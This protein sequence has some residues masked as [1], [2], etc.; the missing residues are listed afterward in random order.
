M[1]IE[2]LYGKDSLPVQ[3][4]PDWDVSIIRKKAMPILADAKGAIAAALA[5]PVNVAPL[6]EEAKGARSAC[7][8][9]CDITRPVP[10]GLFLPILV[11]QLLDAG[12]AA[13]K[14]TIL[15][16][17]GLHRPNE[18]DEMRELV[19]DDWVM[20]TVKVA[21][22][23]ARND[24]DHVDL[25]V[26]PRGTAVKIDRRFVEADI[27]IATGL[28]EPHF[29]AGWSGGRKV[30]APGGAPARGELRARRQSFARRAARHRQDAR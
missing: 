8:L 20:N 29:M 5:S 11:Q 27:R 28:V 22:H 13:D 3:L 7:I 25:G 17:T 2:L 6:A 24:E 26:T 1:K 9:I 14:I 30:I 12:I 16:A 19:G 4:S 18:G 15:V 21:N 10:N 23:F